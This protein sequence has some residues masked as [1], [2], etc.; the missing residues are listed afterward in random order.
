M[1][2]FVANLVNKAREHGYVVDLGPATAQVPEQIGSLALDPDLR[3]LL[4]H[5]D[6][7]RINTNSFGRSWGFGIVVGGIHSDPS[8]SSFTGR[9]RSIPRDNPVDFGFEFDQLVPFAQFEHL[10]YWLCCAPSLAAVDGTQP[11]L[12]VDLFENPYGIPIASSVG[13]A[14]S[15]ITPF[16]DQ[17][18]DGNA[19]NFLD[20]ALHLSQSDTRL[21]ELNASGAFEPWRGVQVDA[22]HGLGVLRDSCKTPLS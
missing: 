22:N 16:M 8:L 18:S 20:A 9:L 7:I 1:S 11:V 14:F 4:S 5:H 13:A 6:G 12:F 2:N 3:F 21:A 17:L 10:D 19:V 15:V